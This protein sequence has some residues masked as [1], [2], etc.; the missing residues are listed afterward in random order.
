MAAATAPAA[1]AIE[2]P[3]PELRRIQLDLLA[4]L[5]DVDAICRRHGLRYWLD[6]GTLLGAVR[7]CGFIPWDDDVDIA[8]PREDYE[9]FLRVADAE[10]D[11]RFR[12]HTAET[13]PGYDLYQVPCKITD[14]TSLATLPFGANA[15]FDIGV[16]ILPI[17]KYR[18][19]G[20]G[21]RIDYALKYLYRR[22]CGVNASRP[23]AGTSFKVRAN[24]AL[25][26]SKRW[27]GSKRVVVA[28]RNALRAKIE[29]SKRLD[30]DYRLGYAFDSLWLRFFE[31]DDV[32]PLATL[33]FE[34]GAF[35][36]P[37]NCDAVLRVFYG[38][39]YMQLPDPSRRV[40]YHL[41]FAD[42]YAKRKA[43]A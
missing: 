24:N 23:K 33:P 12:L 35:F 19:S 41:A 40:P 27:L 10:L 14:P 5:K 38:A 43:P 2:W 30:S 22:L 21:R 37:A 42:A 4:I 31:I 16:D 28:Y 34:D 39:S 20:I 18:V 3:T 7:H 36:V 15:G 11:K 8:M 13:D 9:A 26:H 29:R 6:G 17:D 1:A 32:L 25:A